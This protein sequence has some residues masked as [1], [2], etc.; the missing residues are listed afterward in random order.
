M[1]RH[2]PAARY[3]VEFD[4]YAPIDDTADCQACQ[5]LY[6][7]WRRW[8]PTSPRSTRTTRDHRRCSGKVG[9]SVGGGTD[10]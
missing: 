7:T 8:T 6:T 3:C 10:E 4:S 1:H 2:N 5:E 9:D